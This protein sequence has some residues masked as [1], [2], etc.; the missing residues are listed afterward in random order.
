MKPD[1]IEKLLD[2]EEECIEDLQRNK[3]EMTATSSDIR[4][5]E[6]ADRYTYCSYTQT[7]SGRPSDSEPGTGGSH[8]CVLR[9]GII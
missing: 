7:T 1:D 6:T 2:F 5:Q 4:L 8:I 9:R 3:D